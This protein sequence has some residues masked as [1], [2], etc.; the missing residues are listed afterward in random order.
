MLTTYL[1]V[2]KTVAARFEHATRLARNNDTQKC[3][4]AHHLNNVGCAI[5]CLLAPEI[6]DLLESLGG[7]GIQRIY[8]SPAVKY[9]IDQALDVKAIGVDNL[10]AMQNMHDQATDVDSFRRQLSTEIAQLEEYQ[11]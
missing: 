8:R 6:A 5:G 2:L 7:G 11:S 3:V 9:H 10:T 4:Y 1:D